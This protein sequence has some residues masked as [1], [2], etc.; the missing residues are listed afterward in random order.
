MSII[1]KESQPLVTE[2]SFAIYASH[3]PFT[4]ILLKQRLASLSIVLG[5]ELH[6]SGCR[7]RKLVLSYF[8]GDDTISI[9]GEL[10]YPSKNSD[11]TG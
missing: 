11:Y 2:H 3:E 7:E 1:K 6:L 8:C 4:P 5:N 9:F 10:I